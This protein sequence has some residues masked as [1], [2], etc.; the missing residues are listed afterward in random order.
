MSKSAMN[1]ETQV[2]S[3]KTLSKALEPHQIYTLLD[4]RARDYRT[5]LLG[6]MAGCIAL[7]IAM[8]NSAAPCLDGTKVEKF[9]NCVTVG[10]P[11]TFLA[12]IAIIAFIALVWV[13]PEIW[14]TKRRAEF[15]RLSYIPNAK[16]VPTVDGFLPNY[17][18]I[19]K[20]VSTAKPA[21]SE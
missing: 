13:L 10:V 15:V 5:I 1:I 21:T 2:P 14:L 12:M 3:E 16:D 6:I 11:F 8:M 7:F 17:T 18:E 20:K 9:K 19:S 4:A